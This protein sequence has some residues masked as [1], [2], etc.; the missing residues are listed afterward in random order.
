MKKPIK[1][2]EMASLSRS[3]VR[4]NFKSYMNPGLCT[5]LGLLDLDKLYVRAE[6]VYVWDSEGNRYLDFLGGFG[7]LNL[8]H[9]HPRIL[10]ALEQVTTMPNLLQ[11]SM[12]M[13]AS[14]LAHNLAQITPGKL[15][16][17]FFCNSGAEA[18][19]GAIKLARIAT[20]RTRIISCKSG[21]HGKTLGSLS[22]TGREKYQK[23]FEPLLPDCSM[24]QFCGLSELEEQLKTKDV[25]GFIVE[26]IQ[27]EGGI[28]VPEQGYLKAA[29]A[30]CRRYG[31]LLIVDEIQTGLGRTGKMFAVEHDNVEPDILCLAKSL[32]GG[33]MPIGAVITTQEIWNKAYGGIEKCL[34]HTSTFGGN[35]WAAA[36]GIAT[37]EVIYEEDLAARAAELGD[38]LMSGLRS[39]QEK[40]PIIADVR[41]KGLLV[42]LEFEQPAKGVLAKVAGA[43]NKLSAEY[44]GAMVAG[45]LLNQYKIITAYTLNNPN[46][47]RFEPPL[48][49]TKEQLDVLLQALEEI[50]EKNR[51][52]LGFGLSSS[53]TML[54]GLFGKKK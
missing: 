27:G 11:A 32:G 26:P 14:T 22:V 13:A 30:L 1:L 5:L 42:G 49:V 7:S 6:G 16:N 23:G 38:Y 8:G 29:E 50:F 4:E 46:V 40:Y 21:F 12:G 37:L 44:L 34:L 52:L 51:S 28:I 53:K 9:N 10:A 3:Q 41:G 17:T 43:V 19:E 35:T 15:N 33:I 20:G 45:V 48:I 2:A 25:A 54:T 36:A 18:V 24:V 47:I 31:A 39:L